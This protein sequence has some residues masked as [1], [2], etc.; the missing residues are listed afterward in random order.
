MRYC[1]MGMV[2]PALL[3]AGARPVAAAAAFAAVPAVGT[4]FERDTLPRFVSSALSLYRNHPD[5]GKA[6]KVSDRWVRDGGPRSASDSVA[7]A[8]VWRRAGRTRLALRSLPRQDS[9][10]WPRVELERARVLFQATP[11]SEKA[12]E[13]RRAAAG[14]FWTACERAD[15]ATLAEMWLD[16]RGL[17]TP[18][19]QEEWAGLPP[20]GRACPWVRRFVER[21]AMRMA[22]TPEARLELHY[23][24][25]REARA[26]YYLKTPRLTRDLADRLGRADSLEID[27]RGLLLLR[28]GRPDAEVAP[29]M[30]LN[31]TWAYFR[32]GGARIYHFAPVS[33]TGYRALGDFRLLENL[34]HA[35]GLTM[36]SELM[37]VGGGRFAYLYRS[38]IALDFMLK[39]SLFGRMDRRMRA[40]GD[41]FNP[42]F[43]GFLAWER[44]RNEEDATYA[45][46]TI[47][48]APAITPGVMFAYETLR[49]REVG[50]DDTEV[51]VLASVRAGDLTAVGSPV[52]GWGVGYRLAADL[53]LMTPDGYWLL[54][55][56]SRPT[57]HDPLGSDDGIPA[58]VSLRLPPG[59]Y[60]FTLA[61]RDAGAPAAAVGNWVHDTLT[62]A[63]PIPGLPAVSDLAVAA[64]SGGD[65]SRDGETF[66]R[67]DPTHVTSSRGAA[68]LYFEVYG[69]RPGAAYEVEVRVVPETQAE[70]M[71][72]MESEE[73]AFALR[74]PSVAEPGVLGFSRHHLR[75]DLG[76][77]PPGAYFLSVTV[78][79]AGVSSLPSV[80]PV[81]RPAV[82][83]AHWTVGPLRRSTIVNP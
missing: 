63:G 32:P 62:V 40:F 79:A 77:S 75:V 24:R 33:R 72:R 12:A 49:F 13:N 5:A 7:L 52:S 15:A 76:A 39:E 9:R 16:L 67:V 20:D 65:W 28:M 53:A 50:G 38:R 25:L 35:S 19:E 31:E 14:A 70:R 57:V 69:L 68:H 6:A 64:D 44:A 42:G 8:A 66:L 55:G 78:T 82:R 22:V 37:G 30:G 51:W 54:R 48:D 23:T 45:V 43:A 47:P 21:R 61:I 71:F 34:A 80:T 10:S 36:P 27:D 4:G 2:A 56:T 58:R 81:F 1:A 73:L 3:A 83:H 18:A 59:S 60:P 74:F 41:R 29:F 46:Q 11:P 17:A 26:H